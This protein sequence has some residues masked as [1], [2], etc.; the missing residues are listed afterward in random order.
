MSDPKG[1][2]G[3]A[4]AR[5]ALRKAREEEAARIMGV[6][7]IH[8]LIYPTPDCMRL[9]LV[10]Y[11]TRP[12]MRRTCKVLREAQWRPKEV[13]EQKL[14]DWAQRALAGWLEAETLPPEEEDLRK[15]W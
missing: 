10:I 2:S 1:I 9:S 15:G 4:A 7:S 6:P 12:G 3:P 11:Y 14:I 13:S 8:L 5:S